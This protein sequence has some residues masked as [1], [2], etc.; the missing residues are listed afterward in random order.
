[1]ATLA[2]IT[3]IKTAISN[4]IAAGGAQEVTIEGKTVRYDLDALRKLLASYEQSYAAA[5][6]GKLPFV[7]H[8]IKPKGMN[9]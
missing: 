8:S 3:A 9:C 4:C 2:E 7:M 6:S 1:M 5:T